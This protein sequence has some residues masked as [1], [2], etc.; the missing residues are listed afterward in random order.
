[1]QVDAERI[2]IGKSLGYS[3]IPANE[4]FHRA[5][6]GPEGDL[7]AAING[8]YM[9]TRLKAPGS[10]E[11]RWLTEDF[12]YGL[13]SWSSGGSQ[14]GVE[15]PTMRGLVDIGSVVMG[16]DGWSSGRSVV[17]LGIEGMDQTALTNYLHTA[18]VA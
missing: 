1:M 2:A 14:Y 13:A 18:R 8:S 17:E 4:A 16:F 5:G 12:P 9:L 11:S 10:L 3:L 7:W 6:F 15:T